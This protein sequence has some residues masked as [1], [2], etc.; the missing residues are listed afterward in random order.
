M[1]YLF[2]SQLT[3]TINLCLI[4]FKIKW[5]LATLL[6]HIHKKFEINRTKIKG[7]CQSERKVVTHDCKWFLGLQ[8]WWNFSQLVRLFRITKFVHIGSLIEFGTKTTLESI[9]NFSFH[10]HLHPYDQLFLIS[11]VEL[12]QCPV[13]YSNSHVRL[14]FLRKICALNRVLSAPLTCSWQHSELCILHSSLAFTSFYNSLVFISFCLI[15]FLILF[16][17]FWHLTAVCYCC[18]CCYS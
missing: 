14:N 18:Y 15:V 9:L 17:L 3:A 6:E 10:W 7:G 2:P 12:D 8:K 4:Y 1:G 13:T 11:F 16:Y 5:A